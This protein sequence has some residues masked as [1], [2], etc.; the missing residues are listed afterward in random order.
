MKKIF[1]SVDK[2]YVPQ[3]KVALCSILENCK[4]P[5]EIEFIVLNSG[6]I[7]KEEI[8]EIKNFVKNYSSKVIFYKVKKEKYQKLD[9]RKRLSH[10]SSAAYYRLEIPKICKNEKVLYLDC[11]LVILGNVIDLW[12]F[13]LKNK[14]IGAVLDY[15][16]AFVENKREFNSGVLVIDCKK[17][18]KR[19]YNKKIINFIKNDKKLS[20]DQEI[21]NK[22]IKDDWYELPLEWNRQKRAY[23][24]NHKEMKITKEYYKKIIKNP[25]IIH[26]TGRIKPWHYR[27][28]FPDK[29]Y[30]LYYLK[31]AGLKEKYDDKNLINFFYRPVRWLVYKLKM[32]P[33]IEK[34][35]LK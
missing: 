21:L 4:N 14:T 25:K 20:L 1:F 9:P 34:W 23:E 13:D 26:Y 19:K 18:N 5:K 8:K 15:Y 35:I 11:D 27:Y 2:N 30:Y 12:K 10:L 24:S 29:K 31:K 6:E 16:L 3:L 22:I 32:R 33:L 28:I 7:E 17:W